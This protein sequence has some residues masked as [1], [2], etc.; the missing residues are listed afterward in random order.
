MKLVFI[1]HGDPDYA[2]DG[3][4]ETGRHEAELLRPRMK[5][6]KGDHFYV[7]PLGRAR[8]TAALALEGS[9]IEPEELEWLREFCPKP[10]IMRPD[11]VPNR[12]YVCWDWLPGDWTVREELYDR[13]RWKEDPI[14]LEGG[15]VPEY[16]RVCAE[17]DRLLAAHGYV[18]DGR[19]YR[20][21]KAND[22]T[23]VFFCHFGVTGVFL[24]HLMGASPMILWQGLAMAPTSV[25]V[26]NT[27]ERREGIAGFRAAQ[28]GDVS[29]LYA[30]GEKP[31]F[32]ARFCEMYSNGKERH[33]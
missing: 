8:Q 30:A 26:V 19:L 5:V 28:V 21:E 3:L 20:V 31:S 32:S 24:S 7:S 6:I 9:G 14:M 25:T 12:S 29:H 18:R 17:F 27:E 13:D 2:V 16:E 10:G 15:I 33:D 1:R 23:L 4:T 11:R 22:E